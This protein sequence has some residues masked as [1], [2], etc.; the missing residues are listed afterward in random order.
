MLQKGIK[1]DLSN[2]IWLCIGILIAIF[3]TYLSNRKS[4]NNQMLVKPYAKIKSQKQRIM[5]H[6]SKV[7][8]SNTFRQKGNKNE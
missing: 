6:N 2:I 1:M 4:N 3:F 7:N 8:S 5:E